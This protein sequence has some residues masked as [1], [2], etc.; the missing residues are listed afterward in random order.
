MEGFLRIQILIKQIKCENELAKY[1]ILRNLTE[2][3][4]NFVTIVN[5]TNKT[6]CIGIDVTRLT[7]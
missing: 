3:R 7:K 1:K 4:F 6:K 5:V 2:L